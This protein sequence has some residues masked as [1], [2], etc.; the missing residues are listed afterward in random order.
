VWYAWDTRKI[1]QAAEKQ[2]EALH[3]P[4]LTLVT[5]PRDC[6]E[7][8][9]DMDDA[10]GG[11]VLAPGNL[12]LENIGS[13]PAVNVRFKFNPD[14][15]HGYLPNIRAG[16]TFVMAVRQQALATGTYEF[17]ANYQ[18]LSDQLYE[19]RVIISNSVL[20]SFDFKKAGETS[21]RL[22]DL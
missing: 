13:G 12:I 7:A 9:L 20:T 11:T 4:C 15:D 5:V 19:S 18:S 1:R 16:T 17:V 14:V 8:I 22:T 10:V 3:K 21:R 2:A 6:D